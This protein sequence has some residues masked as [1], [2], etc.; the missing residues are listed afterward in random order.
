MFTREEL[1]KSPEYWFEGEQNELFRQVSAYMEREKINQ[2]ELANRLNVSKGY[3]SQIL[4][5]NFNYTLKKLIEICLS[6]GVVPQIKYKN[7]ETVIKEDAYLNYH[8]QNYNIEQNANVIKMPPVY[9]ELAKNL[10]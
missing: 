3:I 4:D 9:I 2:T 1:L 8:Y 6:I 5:G 7:V 10:A